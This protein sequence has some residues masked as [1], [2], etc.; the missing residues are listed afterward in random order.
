[1]KISYFNNDD[2]YNTGK[3]GFKTNINQKLYFTK[4][5]HEVPEPA[6]T[7]L[8]LLAKDILFVYTL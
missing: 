5:A 2:I 1:L 4:K 3:F 8:N 6:R 7:K